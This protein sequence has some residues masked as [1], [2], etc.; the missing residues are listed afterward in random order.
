MLTKSVVA[1]DQRRISKF[2]RPARLARRRR[3]AVRAIDLSAV[4]P[5]HWWRHL[6]ADA[7]TAA[8]LEILHRSISGIIIM[9]EP[10]WPDAVRGDPAAA[11]GVA[12]R[13][14]KRHST[15]S[16]T[17]DLVMSAVLLA[18]LAGDPVAVLVLVLVLTKMI[19]WKGSDIKKSRLMAS[20]RGIARCNQCSITAV[21]SSQRRRPNGTT[22]GA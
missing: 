20:W 21:K 2:G 4:P 1:G 19:D 17:V 13:T 11:I 16:P 14:A 10:R 9:N 15:P 12:L 6:P 3:T 8:H 18:A 7:Y 5:L 22:T